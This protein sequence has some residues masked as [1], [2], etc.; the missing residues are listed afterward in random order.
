MLRSFISF[1]VGFSLISCSSAKQDHRTAGRYVDQFMINGI[2]R[3]YILRIPKGYD[4]SKPTPFVVALHGLTSNMEQLETGLN[5]GSKSDSEGFIVAIPNGMP[6]N[7]RGW[8]AGFF[9]LAGQK[10]DDQFITQMMDR[11]EKEFNVDKKRVYLCGHSNG[12]M[13]S[14]R[15][16]AEFSDRFAAIAGIAGTVGLPGRQGKDPI[17]VADPKSKISVLLI[18]GVKDNVV[19]Y[20]AGDKAMLVPIGARESGAWWQ[21]KVGVKGE[22]IDQPMGDYAIRT[23]F[24]TDGTNR[25]ELISCING[26]HLIPSKNNSSGFNAMDEIWNFFKQ[27]PK[28]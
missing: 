21:S 10:D 19:A 28:A 5:L 9:G 24:P 23:I 25:I 13:M 4:H 12:A 7:F 1:V 20:K 27:N 15:L 18:H 11:V 17:T 2:Q 3:E 22:A 8:N 14:Y 6:T 16:G 26:N